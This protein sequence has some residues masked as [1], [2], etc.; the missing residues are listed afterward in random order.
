[1]TDKPT[2]CL[3]LPS[4]AAR[5]QLLQLVVLVQYCPFNRFFWRKP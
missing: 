5:S 2:C 3:L 1:M 4:F